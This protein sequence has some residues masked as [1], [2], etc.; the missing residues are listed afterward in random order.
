MMS[1][2]FL[3]KVASSAFQKNDNSSFASLLIWR[4]TVASFAPKYRQFYP[5]CCAQHERRTERNTAL[6]TILLCELLASQ[7]FSVANKASSKFMI[8]PTTAWN[9]AFQKTYN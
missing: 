1:L 6:E 7:S 9:V 8:S 3:R 4:I 2:V 5:L